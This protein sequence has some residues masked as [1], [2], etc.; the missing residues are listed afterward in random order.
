MAEHPDT[1]LV[2]AC[3]AGDKAAQRALMQRLL[4]VVHAQ[5]VA[6]TRRAPPVRSAIRRE[7]Q[8]LVQ[9]V[10]VELLR[11]DA[12][13]LRRWSPERG[14]TLEGFARLVARRFATKRILGRRPEPTEATE[15]AVIEARATAA[16]ADRVAHRD[17]LDAILDGLYAQMTP[18]DRELFSR[19][20][21]EEQA[22][23]TVVEQLGITP[24]ALKKWRSRLYQRAREQAEKIRR[25]PSLRDRLAQ[26]KSMSPPGD[27]EPTKLVKAQGRGNR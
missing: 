23:A 1:Q 27:G 2:K 10:L 15:P 16:D 5:V 6:V 26:E 9:D 14:L 11:N 12:Q 21:L 22:P 4:P 13:E 18:R 25:G 3:A 17:E 19:L 8:D 7:V 20:F 24:A